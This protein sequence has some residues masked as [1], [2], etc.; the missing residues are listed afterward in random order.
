MF[1]TPPP[2]SFPKDVGANSWR[3]RMDDRLL[4]GET[5]VSYLWELQAHILPNQ[6]H[7]VGDLQDIKDMM[8]SLLS[9]YPPS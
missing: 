9:H 7:M 6:E 3:S 1:E 2:A 4:H 5:D 8:A